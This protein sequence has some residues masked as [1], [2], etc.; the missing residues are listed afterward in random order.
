MQLMSNVS[1][2]IHIWDEFHLDVH[3]VLDVQLCTS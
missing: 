2:A 3:E 1:S